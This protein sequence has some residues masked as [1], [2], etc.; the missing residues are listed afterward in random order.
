M[1]FDLED[2]EQKK[3]ERYDK[4]D[5]KKNHKFVY[6]IKKKEQNSKERPESDP[7]KQFKYNK[8]TYTWANSAIY[9][10]KYQAYIF[11]AQLT[12]LVLRDY[13]MFTQEELY[14]ILKETLKVLGNL[15]PYDA[16]LALSR[17]SSQRDH[18][19]NR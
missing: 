19:N 18:D 8:Q 4:N 2:S 7:E 17:K 3:M 12:P 14:Q 6:E 9:G 1:I 16:T 11:E 5:K 10:G 15:V 13:K